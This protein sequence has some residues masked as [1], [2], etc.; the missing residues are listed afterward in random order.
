MVTSAF[1]PSTTLPESLA[2][3][4]RMEAEHQ[5]S[6]RCA[7]WQLTG[8]HRGP[9]P[10][11]S[12]LTRLLLP[13]GNRAVPQ[14][15]FK[16]RFGRQLLSFPSRDDL[17]AASQGDTVASFVF[18]QSFAPGARP[19]PHFTAYVFTARKGSTHASM[20]W[21]LTK[22]LVGSEKRRE[23]EEESLPRGPL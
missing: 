12:L 9:F 15:P 23:G 17:E 1:P 11:V 20:Q 7:R 2:G 3:C 5:A 18:P 22:I 19:P 14:K 16:P 4:H 10:P 13:K 6:V 8:A 21:Q